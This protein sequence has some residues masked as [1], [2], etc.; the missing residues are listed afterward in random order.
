MSALA[1]IGLDIGSLSIQAVEVTHTK[2]KPVISNFGQALLPEGAMVGGVVRDERAVSNALRQLW[3]AHEF[4]SKSVILGVSHQQVVVREV[5]ISNLPPREMRQALPF[6]VRDVLPLP[7]E[8]AMLDFY[9]LENAEGKDTVRGLLIAAPKEAVVDTV[10]AV[11]AAGLHV[12]E[13]DLSCFA[14]LRSAAH[15]TRDTEAIID[16]GA[17]TT[18][19]IIHT[20]GIPQIVRTIPRGGEE[21]TALMAARLDMSLAEAEV[22]KCRVGMILGEG[23]E[24]AE[25]I[26]EAIRPLIG[27][28]RGSVSYYTSAQPGRRVARLALVGGAALLPGLTDAI[29]QALGV[30][31]FVADPLQHVGDSRHGGRHD[32]LGRF[33]SSAAVSIGLTLGAA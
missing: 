25:V 8:Q 26:T 33:R 3:S 16:I 32:V 27:E 29:G 14:A 23:L 9:P 22:V 20:D 17:T 21:I 15:P 2:D 5:E 13:V 24:V 18:N 1:P 7:V 19:I 31:T 12:V 10:R 4:N 11:E 6:Q 30:P 28:I